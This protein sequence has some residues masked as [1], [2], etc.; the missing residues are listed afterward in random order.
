MFTACFGEGATHFVIMI[1]LSSYLEKYF[2]KQPDITEFGASWNQNLQ[3]ATNRHKAHVTR[4][5]QIVMAHGGVR[6]SQPGTG[7]SSLRATQAKDIRKVK[8]RSGVCMLFFKISVTSNFCTHMQNCRLLYMVR[9]TENGL[10]QEKHIVKTRAAAFG[11]KTYMQ[12][13]R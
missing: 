8:S 9:P 7:Y 5:L 10:L 4:C 6:E 11:S 12:F 1:K 13:S 3:Q 2:D